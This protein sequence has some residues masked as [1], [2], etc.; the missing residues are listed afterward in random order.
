[1]ASKQAWA[2]FT[3]SELLR[4]YLKEALAEEGLA[5]TESQV[6]LWS[7]TRIRI[8]RDVLR[9]VGQD[10][11]FALAPDE[12]LLARRDSKSLASWTQRFA[13]HFSDRIHAELR[14]LVR[15]KSENLGDARQSL[16]STVNRI[17]LESSRLQASRQ[18]I[19]GDLSSATSD[20]ARDAANRRLSEVERILGPLIEQKT[21]LESAIATWDEME[22][23]ASAGAFSV[24]RAVSSMIRL[25]EDVNQRATR[26]ASAQLTQ[27]DRAN[28]RSLIDSV[29]GILGNF[30]DESSSTIDSIL[31]K[32]AF[33]YQDYRLK[34]T[35]SAI[36]YRPEARPE[37]N[38]RR[39][40]ALEID[41]II[42]VAVMVM[43]EVFWADISQIGGDSI[44][45][46]LANEFRYI[47]AVDEATDFSS[48]ELACMRMLA[49]PALD[50]VTFAGDPMQRMT[51]H[52]IQNW[53][54]LLE[55]TDKPEIHELSCS[56]R[57]TQR[58]LGIGRRLYYHSI[59]HELAIEAGFRP[60][61]SD[62]HPIRYKASSPEDEVQWLVQR[63]GE[64]YRACGERLPSIALLTADEGSI[65]PLARRLRE[66]LL[67]RFGIDVQE[68]PQG[69]VLGTQAKVRV[70]SVE[71]IKGLEFESVFFVGIDRMAL[72]S[73]TLVDRFLYVGLT[74]ARSFL[75]VTYFD[76]F[77]SSLSHAIDCFGGSSWSQ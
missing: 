64:I 16:E 59:G 21:G 63:I 37:I 61:E 55:L 23:L 10:R 70:F 57:Q 71:Y 17:G 20:Q 60:D 9:L 72:I 53:D 42:Y 25:R 68:C 43:R 12:K 28:A 67:G 1:M 51:S 18:L 2:L 7:D 24:G 11:F 54:E 8:G 46:R 27:Q 75:G 29:R 56:Y 47:V 73:P 44:T 33:L 30:L 4:N 6:P 58:L 66:P 40:E 39:I 32:L 77:P 3:P 19:E 62:P 50:C 22:G 36:F 35:D 48:V 26:I 76:E 38:N 65:R 34:A 5:A 52:G 69:Q 15:D 49:H 45:G 14:N 13:A 31:K 74:R 41:S